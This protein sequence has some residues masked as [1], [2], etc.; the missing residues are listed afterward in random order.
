MKL[1]RDVGVTSEIWQIFIRDSSSTTG[2][3]LTGLTNASSGLT[4]Y[5]HRDT[6]T[7][8]TAISLVSMTV[9][10]FTSSGFKE[11]DATNMPGWYQFCPPNAALAS[12]AKSCSFHLKGATNMAP[13]PIEVDL[14]ADVNT[15]R[16]AGTSVTGMP[17]PT[18]TQP[19]GF[20]AATFPATVSSLTQMDVTGGTYALNSASFA[21]NAALPLTTQQKADVTAAVPTEFEI[22]AQ[23]ASDVYVGNYNWPQT[24]LGPETFWQILPST[25][26][27]G[28]PDSAAELLMRTKDIKTKTDQLTFTVTN[29]VDSTTQSG[30]STLTTGDIPTVGAIADQVWDEAI[31]GHLTAGST[32]AALNSAGSAGDP[33]GTALPG[34]Y[35][36]GSAGYIL[37]TNLDAASSTLA[38]PTNITAAS[39]VSLAA[40]QHVIV[41]S[42]TVTTLTNLPTI[43][44]NWMTA[45]GLAADAVAE[46]QSGLA[47]SAALAAGVD[48]A[49]INGSTQ[50]AVNAALAW[51]AANTGTAQGGAAQSITLASGASS[52]DDFYIDQAI[53]LV[54]G[55]GAGQTNHITGYVGATRVASVATPWVVVPDGTTVYLPVGRVG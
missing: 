35:A 9:G 21:F 24:L 43:P 36:A 8:A 34:A 11:I 39:G 16:W 2:G 37:G 23:I 12:G 20:L 22:S 30:L 1:L 54:S 27:L 25:Y 17:M 15:V 42:G 18:Y 45:D 7:T 31:A 10:T 41:D 19:T 28:D 55:T 26:T 33:W 51:S 53:F 38:T 13:L 50:A 52:Q 4:A 32:G 47:T 49:S 29:R 40:N 14:K 48:V 5:Y 3:G 44:T 6:D 46:I